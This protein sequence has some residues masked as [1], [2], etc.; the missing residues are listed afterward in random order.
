MN[1]ITNT[2]AMTAIGAGLFTG[3]AVAATWLV[4]TLRDRSL[5]VDPHA[6]HQAAQ[7]RLAT[8]NDLITHATATAALAPDDQF[9]NVIDLRRQGAAS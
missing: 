5:H 6:Q 4:R 8:A 7:E 3:G 9:F 1:L 2:P